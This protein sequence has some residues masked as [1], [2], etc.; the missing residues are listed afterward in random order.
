MVYVIIGA[1][2]R[3]Y[4]ALA[5]LKLGIGLRLGGGEGAAELKV[6]IRVRLGGRG[7]GRGLRFRLG[8]SVQGAGRLRLRLGSYLSFGSA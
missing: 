3:L 1:M 4:I 6:G 7:G 2:R 8:A 5:E